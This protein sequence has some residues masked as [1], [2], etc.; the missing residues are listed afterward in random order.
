MRVPVHNYPMEM[1]RFLL[2]S[3]HSSYASFHFF[4]ASSSP[5]FIGGAGAEFNAVIARTEEAV[6]FIA[7][8]IDSAMLIRSLEAER[9]LSSNE[10]VTLKSIY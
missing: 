8:S 1:P 10:A 3:Y 9:R 5:T 2:F 4:I 6:D 7:E